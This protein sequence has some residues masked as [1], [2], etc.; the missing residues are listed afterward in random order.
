MPSSLPRGTSGALWTKGQQA[1]DVRIRGFKDGILT[2]H[3]IQVDIIEHFNKDLRDMAY[4]ILKYSQENLEK[5]V[6]G[7]AGVSPSHG[8]VHQTRGYHLTGN[9]YRSGRVSRISSKEAAKGTSMESPAI[10]D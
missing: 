4:K 5:K 2:L 3:R 6:Y 1:F 8:G 10:G 7:P 9:L